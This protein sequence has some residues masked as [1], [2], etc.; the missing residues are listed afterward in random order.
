MINPIPSD[1]DV[2]NWFVRHAGKADSA[3]DR[4]VM[5]IAAWIPIIGIPAND[6]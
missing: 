1:V 5:P 6:R 2:E 4:A 3:F